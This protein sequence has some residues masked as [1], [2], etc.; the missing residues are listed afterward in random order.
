MASVQLAAY[1]GR[2]AKLT[3]VES[4]Y[5]ITDNT[6]TLTWTLEVL[7]GSSNYYNMYNLQAI[8]NGTTVYGPTTKEW[9][10]QTFPAARGTKTGTVI[11]DHNADGSHA[12][13][14]FTLKGKV[15]NSGTETY[16][17]T[18]SLTTIPR[19][20]SVSI[21]S[22]VTTNSSYTITITPAADN[23][24]SHIIEYSFKGLTGTINTLNTGTNSTSWTVPRSLAN[25]LPNSIESSA[26]ELVIT[27]KTYNGNT[28]DD[29]TYVGSKTCSS[30][31][32]VDSE[33]VP[34]LATPAIQDG[35]ATVR[36]KSWGVY[37]Q[38]MSYVNI[39]SMTGTGSY[40]STINR[41][42]ATFEGTNYDSDSIS[43][44][45][46][47][48]QARGL[49]TTGSRSITLW[50]KDSRGRT[51]STKTASY[52]VVAYESP[53]INSYDAYRTNSSGTA[54][55]DGTYFKYFFNCSV[56]SC[57][58]HNPM[59]VKIRWRK[60]GTTS[61]TGSNTPK[62]A[63]TSESSYNSNATL[64]GG[65]ITTVDT[66]EI[67]F[68]VTDG[69][70]TNSRTKDV[71]PAFELFHFHASGKAVA[72]GKKS[73]AGSSEEL[74]EVNM[75]AKFYNG[76][77]T[78]I[79]ATANST[80]SITGGNSAGR[81]K[82]LYNVSNGTSNLFPVSNNA[83]A[84]MHINK[85]NGNYDSQLG[86][87]SN[88][89]MYYKSCNGTT[90]DSQSW[91]R[92]AFDSDIP[93]VPAST[94]YVQRYSWWDSGASHNAND[95]HGG[96]TFAYSSHNCPTAGTIVSFDCSSNNN[97]GLQLQGAYSGDRL[98]FRNRNGDNNTWRNW[99]ELCNLST[100]NSNLP[101]HGSNSNGHWLRFPNINIQICWHTMDLTTSSS[102][103]T[104]GTSG[105]VYYVD[106]TW[107]FPAAFSGNPVVSVT[108][109]DRDT[110]V[111][112]ADIN[113]NDSHPIGPT[114]CLVTAYGPAKSRATGVQ[115]IA[116][117][118]YS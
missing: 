107:T 14:G 31:V 100:L 19:A 106:G 21:A 84:I 11:I 46:S 28:R 78:Q 85:H 73:G 54:T 72:F 18:V 101:T 65:N 58:S 36:G 44:L 52:T 35:N 22:S 75:P 2:T 8:V 95:L 113:R 81:I 63:V 61:D 82:W 5:S 90:L 16:N 118:T 96:T 25:K 97:Y 13:V 68:E 103:S 34:T 4:S 87:S 24:F 117:G 98:F 20:S 38:N 30:K 23:T 110:G 86:F 7:G 26:G 99:S 74:F 102:T 42:Y 111:F 6:S 9:S 70:S 105:N 76:I 93:S 49:P 114:S 27:C 91:K 115:L 66:W 51:S 57:S 32:I 67:I 116:I 48:I 69:F 50:V 89:N 1:Q 33:L 10:T 41:Y 62:N 39:T 59:T 79:Q 17:G 60:K 71:P 64:G 45:N 80:S 55:T 92:I 12:D 43:G 94:N 37:L 3:V 108:A 104:I 47:Q 77:Q 83:N 53:K 56:S 109:I 40:S 15:F 88:G 29:S 112:A